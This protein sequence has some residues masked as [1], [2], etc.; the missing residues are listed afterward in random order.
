MSQWVIL[1]S[2]PTNRTIRLRSGISQKLQGN[3]WLTQKTALS[4]LIVTPWKVP[5]S[6][7]DHVGH[8]A[9]EIAYHVEWGFRREALRWE[10][11]RPFAPNFHPLATEYHKWLQRQGP[12]TALTVKDMELPQAY[13]N[14]H[15]Y[16]AATLGLVTTAVIND[17]HAIATGTAPLDSID[18][19]IARIRIEAEQVLYIARFCEALIKQLLFCTQIS[20]RYYKNASLGVLL[21]TDCRGCK[22]SGNQPHKISLLGSLAHRYHL[23]HE[24]DHCLTRHLSL[25]GRR[26][27]SEAAHSKAITLDIRTAEESRRQLM[28]NSQKLGNDF[29]HMLSHLRDLEARMNSELAAVVCSNPDVSFNPQR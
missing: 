23:C 4:L 11:D 17:S 21:S 13:T 20:P 5:M 25:V 24:F 16:H 10:K 7:G 27:N 8:S 12:V 26:R 14:P 6:A 18:A 9:P 28:D 2:T 1:Y 3:K 22:G 19:E 29:V 15:T